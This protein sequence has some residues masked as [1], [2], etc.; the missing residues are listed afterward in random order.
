MKKIS[1]II[2]HKTYI[3]DVWNVS[4]YFILELK[5]NKKGCKTQIHLVNPWDICTSTMKSKKF[6]NYFKDNDVTDW[7][8]LLEKDNISN[9]STKPKSDSTQSYNQ[10]GNKKRKRND[11]MDGTNNSP[12]KTKKRRI[13]AADMLRQKENV[14]DIIRIVQTI[15]PEAPSLNHKEH[16][17]DNDDR[18]TELLP[19]SKLQTIIIFF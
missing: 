2:G 12:P 5:T 16:N 9:K 8:G 15:T 17:V 4:L 18:Y 3:H 19:I 6:K 11:S 1:K 7:N 14:K 10:P 13:E